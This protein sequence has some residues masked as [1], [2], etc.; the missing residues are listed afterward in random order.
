MNESE[1]REETG[2]GDGSGA[3]NGAGMR[4]APDAPSS[5]DVMPPSPNGLE[6]VAGALERWMTR[7]LP[8]PFALALLLTG[9][10]ALIALFLTDYRLGQ[11][12]G[13]WGGRFDAEGS[14]RAERGLWSLLAFSAQMCLILVTG[15]ALAEAP[16]LRRL[17]HRLAGIPKGPRG[18]VALTALVAMGTA[19]L[20]WGLGLICG[21]LFARRASAAMV[22]KGQ[23]THGPLLAAAGYCGLLVWHGGLSGS[24]PLQVTQLPELQ[25]I[26]PAATAPIP[27]SETIF[28]PFN[29]SLQLLLLLLIP[30][31][32]ALLHPRGDAVKPLPALD[33]DEGERVPPTLQDRLLSYGAAL[34]VGAYLYQLL[35][36]TG[37]SRLDPN[38]VNLLMLS[39]GLALHGSVDRYRDAVS[40]AAGAC[41]GI[42]LCFPLYGGL[43]ALLRDTGLAAM[44]TDWVVSTAPAALF[45]PFVFL[46]AG[47]L[48]LLIPS[49]GGQWAVQ[50]AGVLAGTERLGLEPGIAVLAVA[51]GDAWTNLL[52][53][54]W[55]LPLLA[56]T[57]APIGRVF[58]YT[59]T[60]L[61]CTGPVYLFAFYLAS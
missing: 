33:G 19:L 51:H 30:P 4:G 7:W 11:L 26:V 47:L 38:G 12:I 50:G 28:S 31:F 44:L 41:G 46:S 48:N 39:L 45:Q 36:A 57:R 27:L 13:F 54:F 40:S 21:A 10:A 3:G 24:A 60:L 32:L 25:K 53:P 55:A 5:A 37:L 56:L 34:A 20:N 42:I 29:L 58:A 22:A 18:A 2:D 17:L 49:G 52:Q 14:L 43:M 8:S 1:Q 9:L 23:P 35:S 59:L 61:L 16:P 6:R 15:Y